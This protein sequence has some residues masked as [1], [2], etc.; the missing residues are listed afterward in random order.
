MINNLEIGEK[1]YQRTG[2]KGQYNEWGVISTT[3]KRAII[4]Y[5]TP[6]AAWQ[7]TVKRQSLDGY[8]TNTDKAKQVF[9]HQDLMFDG[10]KMID[11]FRK[12]EVIKRLEDSC[13]KLLSLESLLA[14]EAFIKSKQQEEGII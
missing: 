5:S 4:Q 2:W 12:I 8:F 13:F 6:H 1:L 14:I 9:L 11:I 7:K 10:I 3:S